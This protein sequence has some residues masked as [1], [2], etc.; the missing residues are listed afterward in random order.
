MNLIP[1]RQSL[2]TE[3]EPGSKPVDGLPPRGLQFQRL[4]SILKK[5][6]GVPMN[7]GGQST[8]QSQLKMTTDKGFDF[9]LGASRA[10]SAIRS[11]T[12]AD[13][14]KQVEK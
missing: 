7:R 8:S 14:P 5:S 9:T 11:P 4:N 2:I 10:Q 6:V 3:S 1:T 13:R 12:A